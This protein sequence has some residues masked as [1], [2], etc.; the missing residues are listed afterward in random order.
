MQDLRWLS[1]A[2]NNLGDRGAFGL[3]KALAFNYSLAH[4]DVS[5]NGISRRGAAALAHGLRENSTIK[6][7]QVRG[8]FGVDRLAHANTRCPRHSLGPRCRHT[9]GSLIGEHTLLSCSLE[10]ICSSGRSCNLIPR[11]FVFTPYPYVSERSTA[12]T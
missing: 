2:G 1:L 8:R 10:A 4:L 5:F 3:G 7:I 11:C 6:N 9:V 12:T